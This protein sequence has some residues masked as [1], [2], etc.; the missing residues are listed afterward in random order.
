MEVDSKGD[1]SPS[2]QVSHSDLLGD[3][4][5]MA[6]G[7]PMLVIHISTEVLQHLSKLSQGKF[8]IVT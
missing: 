5:V 6:I 1:N 2:Q 8:F 3:L 7:D 4:A